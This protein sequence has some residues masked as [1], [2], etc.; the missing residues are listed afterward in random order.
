M[1]KFYYF[2]LLYTLKNKMYV[3]IQTLKQEIYIKIQTFEY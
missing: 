1:Y 2:L 3:K